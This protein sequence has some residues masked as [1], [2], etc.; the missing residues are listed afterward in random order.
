M[1]QESS[2][3]MESLLTLAA[4]QIGLMRRDDHILT[5]IAPL[6]YGRALI[7]H[8]Q[9]L[10][11]PDVRESDVPLATSIIL[12]HI[13]L[14]NGEL[15]KLGVHMNGARDIICSRGTC[16]IIH[17]GASQPRVILKLTAARKGRIHGPC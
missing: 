13:E 7:G 4:V 1:A 6:H 11:A 17:A 14:W 9:S 3:L 16:S 2:A 8:Y 5:R 15:I 10:E 12:S